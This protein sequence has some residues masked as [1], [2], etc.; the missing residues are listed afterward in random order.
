LGRAEVVG[1]WEKIRDRRMKAGR[2]R[3]RIREISRGTEA[4]DF[5]KSPL[6][7][8]FTIQANQEKATRKIVEQ[9]KY[10]L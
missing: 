1:G 8:L 5:V 7:E 4:K 9:F 10:I 6:I 3:K 2:S